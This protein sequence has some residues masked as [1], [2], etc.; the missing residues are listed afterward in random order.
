MEYVPINTTGTGRLDALGNDHSFLANMVTRIFPDVDDEKEQ[1]ANAQDRVRGKPKYPW[2]DL[3]DP[4][5][6][7]R[8]ARASE[9]VIHVH[10]GP[11]NSG[12]TYHAMKRLAES[13]SG[14]YCA[15]L[16]LLAWE[17]HD[18]LNKDGVPCD[19]ITGQESVLVDG[20]KHV[21]CTVEMASTEMAVD[22]A[23]IDEWQ[24]TTD[25]YRGWAFSRALMGVAAKEVHVCGDPSIE[26]LCRKIAHLCNEKVV[27]HHYTRLTQLCLSHPQSGSAWSGT[28]VCLCVVVCVCIA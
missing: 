17:N 3:R 14:V 23:V 28:C 27:V 7:Y 20:A 21:A 18:A 5:L 22:C 6:E 26:E 9:R 13:G 19:L 11:T 8:L 4:H 10:V 24:V 16:R 1:G 25:P 12:K 2:A 15:P